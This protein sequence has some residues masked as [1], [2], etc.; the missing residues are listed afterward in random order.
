[1]KT[2]EGT[3]QIKGEEVLYSL[4]YKSGM[5]NIRFRFENN[6]LR[7]SAP[8]GVSL[9]SIESFANEVYPRLKKKENKPI[10]HGDK[11]IV[12]GKEELIPG[13][14]LM[15]KSNQERYLKRRLGEYIAS[16]L[17]ELS[18]KFEVPN[19]FY[20]LEIHKAKTRYGSNSTRSRALSFSLL[21][22]PYSPHIVDS[23]IAHELTHYHVHDH[24]QRFYNFLLSRFPDYYECRKK[25]LRQEYA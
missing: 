9:I 14:S 22:V 11:V 25:L 2:K 4:T 13:F 10:V 15:K 12:L 8:Y 5:K 7:I 24:S 3:F 6:K 21:L 17:P 18:L 20:H 16:R 23:V 1:M 19:D